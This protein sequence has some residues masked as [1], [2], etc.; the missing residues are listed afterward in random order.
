MGNEI[1]AKREEALRD[2]CKVK[3]KKKYNIFLCYRDSTAILAFISF[4]IQKY[5]PLF[6]STYIHQ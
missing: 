5:I 6:Y 1:N 3:E 2:Y 4:P